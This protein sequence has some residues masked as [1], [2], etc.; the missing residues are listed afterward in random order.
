MRQGDIHRNKEKRYVN[1]IARRLD[2]VVSGCTTNLA[3]QPSVGLLSKW[4]TWLDPVNFDH[5]V[6]VRP[7]LGGR[8][9]RCHLQKMVKTVL[10]TTWH[11]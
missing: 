10:K 3:S 2:F 4:R 11:A 6:T 9:V 1:D 5:P 8:N 7:T